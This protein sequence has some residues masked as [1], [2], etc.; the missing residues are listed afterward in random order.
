MCLRFAAR[1]GSPPNQFLEIQALRPIWVCTEIGFGGFSALVWIA[2]PTA[3]T[4][5][6]HKKD[7]RRL[8]GIGVGHLFSLVLFVVPVLSPVR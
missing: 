2:C 7:S 1:F 6:N 8:K 4:F 5:F 3:G